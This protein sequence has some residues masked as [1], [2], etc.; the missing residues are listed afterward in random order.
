MSLKTTPTVVQPVRLV[1]ED[2]RLWV[3]E[4][5]ARTPVR[6]TPC[7][8][9]SEPRRYVSLRDK[10][11]KEVALVESL[12][13]L[14]APSAAALEQT[15]DEVGFVF[16]VEAILSVIEEVEIRRWTLRTQQGERRMQTA[17]D[18]WPRELP[19]GG[20]LVRDVAGD[21]YRVPDPST[22][23]KHSQKLLWAFVR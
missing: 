4:D 14:D 18:A 22:L 8:P 21:L 6:P 1:R 19:S 20:Y 10:D 17:L 3:I 5:G 9:W 13:H 7:F 2:G 11:D 16:E 23:D 12:D 15:L